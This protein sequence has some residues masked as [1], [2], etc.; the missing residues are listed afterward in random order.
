MKYE[1]FVAYKCRVGAF[2]GQP[3]L[4][5]LVSEKPISGEMMR[6][7][8]SKNSYINLKDCQHT[9]CQDS[10]CSCGDSVWYFADVEQVVSVPKVL[11]FIMQSSGGWLYV[12]RQEDSNAGPIQ[13]IVPS[14]SSTMQS[15]LRSTYHKELPKGEAWGGDYRDLTPVARYDGNEIQL[16]TGKM[17]SPALRWS[18]CEG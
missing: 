1:K 13:S 5:R 11:A 15:V 2:S 6:R 16:Y 17:K 3:R 12:A 10:P 4:V 18:G 7:Y 8:V 9:D 14:S